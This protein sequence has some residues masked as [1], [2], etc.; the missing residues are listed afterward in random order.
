MSTSRH[1]I[2]QPLWPEYN[3]L[4]FSFNMINYI[5]YQKYGDSVFNEICEAISRCYRSKVATSSR[6]LGNYQMYP[7]PKNHTLCQYLDS[8]AQKSPNFLVFVRKEKCVLVLWYGPFV[9]PA[10][11]GGIYSTLNHSHVIFKEIV[12]AV[13]LGVDDREKDES[14]KKELVEKYWKNVKDAL[15]K[16]EAKKIEL[17]GEFS[18]II[19]QS[20]ISLT[21]SL[22]FIQI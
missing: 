5:E 13:K 7:I 3:G 15:A 11:L 9:D 8:E 6:L 17:K 4:T 2:D 16:I 19:S 21:C 22:S 1:R 18:W 12:K 10:H 14:S 20:I